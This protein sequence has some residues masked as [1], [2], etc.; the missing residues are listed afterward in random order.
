MDFLSQRV[1]GLDLKHSHHVQEI[2]NGLVDYAV[3]VDGL[4]PTGAEN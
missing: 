3:F 2:T 1:V 4:T